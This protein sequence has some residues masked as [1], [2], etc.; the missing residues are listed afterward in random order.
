[1]RALTLDYQ[2]SAQPGWA[3]WLMLGIGVAAAAGAVFYYAALSRDLSGWEAKVSETTRHTLRGRAAMGAEPR[4]PEE[5]ERELKLANEV[6]QK[7]SVP[8]EAL[9][10]ALERTRGDR[11][12]LLAVEPDARKG[13]VRITAEAKTAEDMLDYLRRLGK[14]AAFSR[15][16]L[17]SHQIQQQDSERPL[18]FS[19]AVNWEQ[20]P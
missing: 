11:I 19:L 7:L 8:W 18:R 1:M 3:G 15:V 13:L 17:V 6:L 10:A 2:R 12:A 20:K 9:F 14:E 4:K 5:T 16:S